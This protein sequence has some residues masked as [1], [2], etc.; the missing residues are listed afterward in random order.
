MNLC[1]R[2]LLHYIFS[3][4]VEEL[5]KSIQQLFFV[6]KDVKKIPKNLEFSIFFYI[7]AP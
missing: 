1:V 7:F 6:Q 4:A 2:H 3:Q 5:Q